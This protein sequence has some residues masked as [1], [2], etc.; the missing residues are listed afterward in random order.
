MPP[1]VM[2]VSRPVYFWPPTR[3]RVDAQ[4]D[5]LLARRLDAGLPAIA[6]GKAKPLLALAHHDFALE[7]AATLVAEVQLHL[8]AL[9]HGDFL[10]RDPAWVQIELGDLPARAGAGPWAEPAPGA[11]VGSCWMKLYRAMSASGWVTAS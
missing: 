9:A 7:D 3:E 6:A 1:L 2:T 11:D 5:V 10:E 8:G 4:A